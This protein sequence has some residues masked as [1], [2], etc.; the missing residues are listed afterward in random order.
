MAVVKKKAELL[1]TALAQLCHELFKMFP[2]QG[3]DKRFSLR[4]SSI[5]MYGTRVN[6]RLISEYLRKAVL[7]LLSNRP[8]VTG[9]A[10]GRGGE[11]VNPHLARLEVPTEAD[12]DMGN[13]QIKVEDVFA[14]VDFRATESDITMMEQNMTERTRTRC[15]RCSRART[16]PLGDVSSSPKRVRRADP[17]EH[18]EI[19]VSSGRQGGDFWGRV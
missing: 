6:L 5:L 17:Q 19:M 16:I 10:S 11:Q 15:G 8:T 3:K 4:T 18:S 14:Q 13:I 9:G 12:I 7:L 1:S 2:V